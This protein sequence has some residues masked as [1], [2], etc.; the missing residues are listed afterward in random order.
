MMKRALCP[1]LVALLCLGL[2]TPA[3]ASVGY[4]DGTTGYVAYSNPG[5]TY[6]GTPFLPAYGG[7]AA[8]TTIEEEAA[9]QAEAP[10]AGGG[11]ATGSHIPATGGIPV[12]M[13]G[14]L[15]AAAVALGVLLR[16]KTGA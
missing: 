7:E 2:M 1:M 9:P 11:V 10:V 3:F 4:S 13:L 8:T 12:E 16:P 14:L 6:G 5:R 15:G